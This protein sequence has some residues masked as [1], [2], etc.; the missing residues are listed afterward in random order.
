M[1]VFHWLM[2]LCFAGA[3]LTAESEVWRLVHVT[4]GYTMLGLAVFR[5]VWGFAGTRY[6]RF[7]NFVCGPSKVSAYLRSLLSRSPAHFVGHNP[8]GA[9]AILIVLA[10][11]FVVGLSGYCSYNDLAGEWVARLHDQASNLML[12]VVMVH[13][14]GV[15]VS[16]RLHQENLVGSMLT[17]YKYG[18]A[19][20]AVPRAWYSLAIALALAV[21]LFWLWQWKSVP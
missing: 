12:L 1:R 6:A 11:A 2:A 17:G 15:I 8:A 16:S 18:A 7:A 9:W 20:D 21:I 10:L 3:Y 4:L 13:V 19:R 5:V 14:G